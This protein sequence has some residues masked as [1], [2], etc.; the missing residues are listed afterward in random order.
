MLENREPEVGVSKSLLTEIAQEA[1]RADALHGVQAHRP[2]GTRRFYDIYEEEA[3]R[4]VERSTQDGS[5]TWFS[6]A[7]EEWWEAAS[8]EDP[9]ALRAELIQLAATCA[10]WVRNIDARDTSGETAS[11]DKTDDPV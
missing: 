4:V 10:R 11:V 6:I 1:M 7:R 2:D 5:L 3:K 9:A 8:E